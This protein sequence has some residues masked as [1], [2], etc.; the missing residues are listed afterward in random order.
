MEEIGDGECGINASKVT[1][2]YQHKRLI[3]SKILAF[4]WQNVSNKEEIV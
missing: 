4:Y 2:F 3:I 1:A